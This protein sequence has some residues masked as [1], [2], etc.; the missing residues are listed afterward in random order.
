[1]PR[2]EMPPPSP[3]VQRLMQEILRELPMLPPEFARHDAEVERQNQTEDE[4]WVRRQERSHPSPP[5]TLSP[6]RGDLTPVGP[7]RPCAAHSNTG[8]NTP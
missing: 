1:M 6:H 8:G 5:D 2:F 7:C 3:E 4:E